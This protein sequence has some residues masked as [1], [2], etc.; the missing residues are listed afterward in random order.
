MTATRRLV[1]LL[2]ACR[3]ATAAAEPA[4]PVPPDGLPPGMVAA[5][6]LKTDM[7]VAAL[8]CRLQTR[9]NTVVLRFRP[10]M[11]GHDRDLLAWFQEA[12]GEAAG[13]ERH[14]AYI[15]DLANGRSQQLH[16]TISDCRQATRLFSGVLALRDAAQYATYAT[17]NLDAAPLLPCP[18]HQ[19]EGADPGVPAR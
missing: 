12:Y 16:L 2:L 15:T 1:P 14:D 18:V 8:T 9:Y 5:Q 19:P 11:A 10:V 4:C 17:R 7:M 13:T 3:I 6:V